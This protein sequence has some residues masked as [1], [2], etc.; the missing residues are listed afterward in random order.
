MPLTILMSLPT[1]KTGGV[2]GCWPLLDVF[3]C[4]IT[5]KRLHLI[6][7]TI[8]ICCSY[9]E[10]WEPNVTC[11]SPICLG[12]SSVFSVML[13]RHTARLLWKSAFNMW[14]RGTRLMPTWPSRFPSVSL[15]F[16]MWLDFY[17]C[18][19]FLLCSWEKLETQLTNVPAVEIPC[20]SK[21]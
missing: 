7:E 13:L 16:R 20:Y 2:E 3:S 18:D 1:R 21:D 6:L 17:E 15:E 19:K 12:K 11:I 8:S 5:F 14:H 10:V 9:E 4:V